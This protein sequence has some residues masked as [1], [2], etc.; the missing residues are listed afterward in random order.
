MANDDP[1][2]VWQSQPVEP[3]YMSIEEIR[4]K[5]ARF[6]RRIRWRNLRETLVALALIPVFGLFLRWFSTPTERVGSGL[7]ILGLLYLIYRMNGL[8]AP[9][10]VPTDGGF[11]NCVTFHRR[12]LE[13]QRDL[14]RTVWL[15]YLG[16]LVP[17]ILVFNLGV[18]GPKISPGHPAQW[19]RAA[20]FVVLMV[21][22]F[23]VVIRLNRR[24]ADRLQRTIDELDRVA[25]E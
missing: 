9:K 22:W 1:I 10:R 25:E 3:V 2:E 12:E 7:T 13:R 8:A 5:A 23:W 16:P 11:Q 6:E 20:P 24:A 17:G 18:L 14:L 19:W 15:W 21:A 4:N